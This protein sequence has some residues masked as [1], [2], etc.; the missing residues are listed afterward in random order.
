M[1]CVKMLSCFGQKLIRKQEA[2]CCLIKKH[3][4]NVDKKF[5]QLLF[6]NLNL[7]LL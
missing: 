7:Q 5:I 2:L 6:I 3:Y 1:V 4:L